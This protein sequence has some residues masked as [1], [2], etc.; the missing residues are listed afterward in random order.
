[1][2]LVSRRATEAIGQ[3]SRG[4]SEQVMDACAMDW[5]VISPQD[6]LHVQTPLSGALNMFLILLIKLR[7]F[8]RP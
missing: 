4:T 1:M 3:S 7:P 2:T 8:S 5:H 6:E